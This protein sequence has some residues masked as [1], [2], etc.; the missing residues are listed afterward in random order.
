ME[1]LSSSLR[2]K[3]IETKGNQL[4]GTLVGGSDD[5]KKNLSWLIVW[6][7]LFGAL[8]GLIAECAMFTI[9]PA[10]STI[11]TRHT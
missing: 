3:C 4:F 11:E 1:R 10:Y 6:G 9:I 5:Q 8:L 7:N 2:F